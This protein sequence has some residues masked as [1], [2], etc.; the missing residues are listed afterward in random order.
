MTVKQLIKH[1]KKCDK[2]VTVMIRVADTEDGQHFGWKEVA[3]VTM[4]GDTGTQR[5]ALWAFE[6][7]LPMICDNGVWKQVSRD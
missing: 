2:N 1:L 6:G 7:N 5:V 4:A 3:L